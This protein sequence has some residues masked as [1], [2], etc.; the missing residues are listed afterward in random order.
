M[1]PELQ[2]LRAMP[3]ALRSL[4]HAHWPLVQKLFINPAW[5]SSDTE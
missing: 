3:T 1:L 4:F 2:Q 5:P